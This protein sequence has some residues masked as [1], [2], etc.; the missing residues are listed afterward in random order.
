MYG[1][2]KLDIGL[3][4]TRFSEVT[5]QDFQW[6]DTPATTQAEADALYQVATDVYEAQIVVDLSL[7]YRINPDWKLTIGANNIFNAYP[8]P[9]FDGW[10]D[11]GGFNDSVQMGSDGAYY[12]ARL[13]WNF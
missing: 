9:Q 8:T 10:T 2:N 6:V 3:T 4:A 1:M 13:G 5:L 11:Q 7:G 12:F